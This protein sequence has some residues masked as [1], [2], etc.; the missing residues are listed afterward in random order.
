MRMIANNLNPS[1]V[2]HPGELIKDEVEAR[3]ITQKRLASDMGVSYTVLNDI[4]CGRRG[5]NTQYA[6]LLEAALGIESNL[7]L[8][9]QADYDLHTAKSNASF[10]EKLKRVRRV[11]AAL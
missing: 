1:E 10:M 3:G 6:L 8:K 2:T 11:A 5:I 7:W 9:L 4:I